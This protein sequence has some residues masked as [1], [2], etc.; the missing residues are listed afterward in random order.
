MR[1]TKHA[2][3]VVAA[4][5]AGLWATAPAYAAGETFKLLHVDAV[6]CAS[7]DFHTTVERGNLDGG[8]YNVRTKVTVDGKIY[9]NESASISVNG[10]SGWTLFSN[11]TYGAVPNPGTW[12]IPQ[13]KQ[14]RI[15]FTLER[16]LGTVLY[17]WTTVVDACNTGVILYNRLTSDDKDKD[18]V[19]VPKDK[20]PKLAAAR[21]NGCPL[22]VRTLTIGY[23][24]TS[25]KFIG[26][27][28]SKGFPKL[29]SGRGVTIWKVR[30]GPD[31]KIATL[32]VTKRGNYALAYP[33][34]NGTYYATAPGLLIPS[35]GQVTK[36]TSLKLRLR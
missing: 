24:D 8:T 13:N 14:L 20:C 15:D 6:G 31:K 4:V 21:A 10:E 30:G 26:W 17:A 1:S 34:V 25:H 16:P 9:M 3:I 18:L 5:V 22:R 23:D 28:Y 27:L 29:Y 36:E 7:G 33:Q 32:K 12:P 2:L 11:F 35:S 19:P